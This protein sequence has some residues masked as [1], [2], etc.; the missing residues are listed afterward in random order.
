MRALRSLEEELLE[1]RRCVVA[2]DVKCLDWWRDNAHRFPR[3]AEQARMVL[4][5]PSSSAPSERVFSK[6]NIVVQ[7]RTA[8]MAAPRAARR[9]FI[10][11]NM[12]IFQRAKRIP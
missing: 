7:K 1:Y 12:P 10:R 9:V 5:A 3:I 11:H 6:L 4:A 2:P 8:R